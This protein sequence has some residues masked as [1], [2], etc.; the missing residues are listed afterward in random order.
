MPRAQAKSTAYKT[1]RIEQTN[2]RML[3]KRQK[4]AKEAADKKPEDG[5]KEKAGDDDA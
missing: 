4:R 2:K 1:L 5:K 3:G